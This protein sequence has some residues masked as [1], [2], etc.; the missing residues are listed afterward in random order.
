MWV[1]LLNGSYVENN[2]FYIGFVYIPHE[3]NV[4]YRKNELDLLS[5][6]IEDISVYKEKGSVIVSGDFNSRIGTSPDFIENDLMGTD[7]NNFISNVID[8]VSYT[9]LT[10]PTICSV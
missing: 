5:L 7:V 8:S 3:N 4:F 1:I 2:H 10:L 6:L 9:H